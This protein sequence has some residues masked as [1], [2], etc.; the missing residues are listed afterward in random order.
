MAKINFAKIAMKVAGTAGGAVA[1][2]AI[3]NK[4][5]PTMNPALRGAIKIAAG[6]FLPAFVPK[7]EIL[8]SVGDGFIASGG[9]DLARKF[10]PGLMGV[11]P[12]VQGIH[13]IEEQA[14]VSDSEFSDWVS[15]TDTAGA[16]QFENS[17]HM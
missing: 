7:V 2:E 1:A 12:P 3:G 10:M 17:H 13:A 14:P 9:I 11:T 15:G 8:S 16:E 6:A 4:V 5:L